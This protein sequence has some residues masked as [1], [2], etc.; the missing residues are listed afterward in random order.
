MRYN[1]CWKVKRTVP[2]ECP[3]FKPDPYTGD[4]PNYHCAVYHIE[5]IIE[6]R[7]MRFEKAEELDKFRANAPSSCF[8]FRMIEIH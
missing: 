2:T 4:Y 3:N 5:T 1:L 7:S 8:D 6:E